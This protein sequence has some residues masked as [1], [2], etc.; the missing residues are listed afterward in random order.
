[1]NI[2]LLSQEYPPE[3]AMG[4]VGTYMHGIAHEFARMGHSVHVVSTAAPNEA[5]Y[6]YLQGPVHVHR[7]RRWKFNVPLLRRMWHSGLP[8]TK[9]Q[10]EY[11]YGAWGE[12]T[13]TVRENQIDVIEATELWAEGFFYSFARQAPI[14]V[15][16]HTP[17]FVLRSLNQMRATPDWNIVDQID[18][19][20]TRRANR[21]VSTSRSLA[22][23]VAKAYHLDAKKIPVI[24]EPVDTRRFQPLPSPDDASK[25]IMYIGQLEPRKGVYTVVDAIPYVVA[26]FPDARF[27]FVGGDRVL[28]GRSCQEIMQARLAAL[29]VTHYAEFLG[30]VPNQELAQ[31]LRRASVCLF[32][33]L[34]EN[35][36]ISCLEAMASARPVIASRV[37]GFV[38]MIVD[39]ESGLLIP[40]SDAPALAGAITRILQNPTEARA[41]A[42]NARARVEQNF[43]VE[44]I[45]RANLEVYSETI[46][47]WQRQRARTA[48]SKLESL[49][50]Q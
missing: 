1:M 44:I 46:D 15:K 22:E 49:R 19:W 4:G 5:T 31:Y 25:I 17:L 39:G 36:A 41:M 32:P 35:F 43:T 29:G 3:S 9:H 27:L 23:I 48:L 12:L 40:P 10:I 37:G 38:D 20:W 2:L 45:A 28:D 11:A 21:I 18:K 14:V 16:L 24:P 34:W 13:R 42:L 30:R 8:W 7:I 6:S 50:P 33:S 26:E 47:E